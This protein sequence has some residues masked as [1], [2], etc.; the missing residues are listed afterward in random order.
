VTEARL[1]GARG[2]RVD[3]RFK[4]VPNRGIQSV[5]LMCPELW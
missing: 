2:V 3:A 4:F 1:A 5:L